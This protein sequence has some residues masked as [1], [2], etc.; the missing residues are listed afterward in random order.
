MK[1]RRFMTVVL[2]LFLF[3]ATVSVATAQNRTHVV[4]PGETLGSIA[5]RYGVTVDELAFVNGITNPNLIYPGQVLIIPNTGQSGSTTSYT[6]VVGDTLFGIARRFGTTVTTLATLNGLRDADVLFVGQVLLIPSQ[7]QPTATPAQPTPQPTGQGGPV[8]TVTYTVQSGDTLGRIAIRFGTTYQ[9]IALLN[10]LADPDLI[11]P[12]Q[13]LIIQQGTAVT[14]TPVTPTPAATATLTVVATSSGAATVASTTTLTPTA[15]LV[16]TLAPTDPLIPDA[17]FP[18]DFQTP[19]PIVARTPIA[20]DT[21]NL[22]VNPDFEGGSRSVD[23]DDMIVGD[24]WQPFYCD[25]PYAPEKC[26][27]LRQG[28]GNPAGLLMGRPSYTITDLD[29]RTHGGTAAQQW[30]CNWQTCRGGIYQ[31]ITTT[32]GATCEAGAFVQSWSTHNP[33]SFASDLVTLDDRAN[34]TWLIKV[35]L[36]GGANAFAEGVLVSQGFGYDAGVYDRYAQISYTFTAI[37]AETT[38]FFEDT[39]LWPFANNYSYLDDVYVRCAP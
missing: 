8:T 33:L 9:Q 4:Q 19:T 1:N 37:G 30:S 27:A 32:P 16:P 10:N 25:Q 28:T 31:V 23:F 39:R 2:A 20:T 22:V 21:A 5:I 13:V 7:G 36:A 6:V 34:S 24:G 12:G 3:L 35:D 17:T 26:P 11:F 14:P 18:P 38:V 29:Y 15:T